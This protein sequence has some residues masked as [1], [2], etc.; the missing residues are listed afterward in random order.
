MRQRPEKM[1]FKETKELE[2]LPNLIESLE[3]RHAALTSQLADPELYK[4]GADRARELQES[5]HAVERELEEAM[6]RW[7]T[8]EQKQA[9]LKGN[10]V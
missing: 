1:S 10:T 2:E 8:L 4:S 6:S 7:E 5:C 3:S 9:R